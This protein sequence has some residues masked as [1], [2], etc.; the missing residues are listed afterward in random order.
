VY[1]ILDYKKS[2]DAWGIDDIVENM[3]WG[4]L[5]QHSKKPMA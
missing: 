5:K 2:Y 3:L 4:P 1:Q